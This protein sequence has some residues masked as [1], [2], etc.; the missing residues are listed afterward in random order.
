MTGLARRLAYNGERGAG[1][2]HEDALAIVRTKAAAVEAIADSEAG[3]DVSHPHSPAPFG[4]TGPN[5]SRTNRGGVTASAKRS[6][7][8][9]QRSGLSADL[10]WR[11]L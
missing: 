10:I 5:G 8:R 2:S 4:I 7:E 11:S 1:N 3:E 6:P 9:L